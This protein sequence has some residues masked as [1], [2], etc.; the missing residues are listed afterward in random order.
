[1]NR[2]KKIISIICII[3]IIFTVCTVS[4]SAETVAVTMNNNGV[5]ETR[6]LIP[7]EA[8]PNP[9]AN[10]LGE[11][12]YGWYT[13][14]QN[15]AGKVETVPETATTVYARY[16]SVI[17]DFNIIKSSAYTSEVTASNSAYLTLSD[18]ESALVANRIL[19]KGGDG[20][21]L[22]G[23]IV[24]AYDANF[25]TADFVGYKLKPSTNYTVSASWKA[26]K[27]EAQIV[28]YSY[29]A[30]EIN[31]NVDSSKLLTNLYAWGKTYN[32]TSEFTTSESESS[33]LFAVI[34]KQ[35]TYTI[36]KIVITDND[37]EVP[38]LPE[39]P[40]YVD[41]DYSTGTITVTPPE[42][43][44]VTGIYVDG[45]K[46]QMA[47]DSNPNVVTVSGLSTSSTIDATFADNAYIGWSA[48]REK[49]DK[50]ST[51]IRFRARIA[52]ETVT[53]A[54]KA[55]FLV[56]P[57]SLLNDANN[58]A[59]ELV[60]DS[61]NDMVLD[62]PVTKYYADVVDYTD[63]Q[64]CIT[65]LLPSER[66]LASG[67]DFTKEEF[68]VVFYVI[69]NSVASYSDCKTATFEK[70]LNYTSI[71]FN[72]SG[73]VTTSE[74]LAGAA[75]PSAPKNELGEEFRG[76]YTDCVTWD[77]DS[78]V[79]IVPATATTVYAR[80]RSTIINF[81]Q[82]MTAGMNIKGQYIK[83]SGHNAV[84]SN[85]V[86]SQKMSSNYHGF[87]I[88]AYDSATFNPL[89]LDRES[90]Y[91][92]KVY[93][94]TSTGSSLINL[95]RVDTANPF[96]TGLNVH[97][98]NGVAVAQINTTDSY[99]EYPMQLSVNTAVSGVWYDSLVLSSRETS[100]NTY[101]F[102]IYIDKIVI[103][104]T[105]VYEPESVTLSLYNSDTAGV[106]WQSKKAPIEPVVQV[107]LGTTFDESNYVEYPATY[108]S[109]ATVEYSTEAAISSYSMKAALTGLVAGNTYTYR[110]YDKGR[111]LG[112]EY[113]TFVSPDSSVSEFKFVHVG[114]SQVDF[115]YGLTGEPF[116][117]TLKGIDLNQ[118]N[119]NFILHT[120]D[121]VEWS[122][123]EKSWSQMLNFNKDYFTSIPFAAIS[124][125]HEASYR[126]GEYET[127][128]HFNYELT[129]QTTNKGI[130]YSFDYG[131]TRFIMLDTNT[132]SNKKLTDAQYNWLISKLQNNPQKWTIVAMH[133]PMYSVGKYGSNSANNSIAL[134]LRAQLSDVF[135]QYGVDL[136]LQGHDHEYFKTYPIGVG[137]VPNSNLT[138]ETIDGIKYVT[139]ANGVTY[140]MNGPAGNQ[141]RT[142]YSIDE[143]LYELVGDTSYASSWA[144]ISVNDNLLTVE[145]YY[146]NNGTPTLWQ[147]YGIK[148]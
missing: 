7:G 88:P 104:E 99:K 13:D 142:P 132:L 123:Y 73:T 11:D 103:T 23:L 59:A 127:F 37:L 117:N 53:A 44:I 28:F 83:S 124:G 38:E 4:V 145:V 95:A 126:N 77:E 129:E 20:T 17:I 110:C 81:N 64:L 102:T 141:P 147:S 111:C 90:E 47:M 67:K 56:I 10:E 1:M 84:V 68:S 125:N 106:T 25:S 35:T 136:V 138:Y 27:T 107:S 65:N 49:S 74:L 41:V 72:N 54:T 143:S 16:P 85:G 133:N 63:F 109:Y 78:K 50:V 31:G 40:D 15:W 86:F 131:N 19:T 76:W 112:S 57:T 26:D 139:N 122:K 5:I 14:C 55:G 58:A 51:G 97:T 80:Y 130:Y 71:T 18:G 48:V 82:D 134:A 96:G 30:G 108:Q 60:L 52:D 114:D 146:Y 92:I 93:A 9:G 148:K 116:N 144:Q 32:V 42:N 69:K 39:L 61:A 121:M 115:S 79:T 45:V 75:M 12:F 62:V 70:L 22:V 105:S 46:V 98:Y 137:G 100:S 66:G 34:Q 6:N 113:F 3:A 140:V 43:K 24:P 128:R 29:N 101:P 120:G 91:T 2:L 36:D 8:M 119:P 94:C 89:V 135:A 118:F 87:T 21:P 33:T